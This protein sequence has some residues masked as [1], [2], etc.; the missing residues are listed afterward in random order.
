MKISMIVAFAQNMVIGNDNELP[1]KLSSD[2]KY[3]KSVT[4][5]KPII[6]GRKTFESIGKPLPG[7]VNII[8]TQDKEYQKEG[9]ICL[10]DMASA[11]E[12]AKTI[13]PINEVDE[14]M[15]VGGAE[16]Y[17]QCMEFCDRIYTTEIIKEFE[18]DSFFPTIDDNIFDQVKLGE[19]LVENN[20][21]HRFNIYER[22]NG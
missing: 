12:M 11:I 2:L 17:K 10:N 19:I 5:K 9:C 8:L 14:I 1:W 20:I 7:R 22:K 16:I 15:I 18:G 6:M 13:C 4:M 21:E 3:F